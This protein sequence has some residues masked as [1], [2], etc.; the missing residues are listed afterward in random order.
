MDGSNKVA[1]DSCA[2]KSPV[3]DMI[4]TVTSPAGDVSSADELSE[5]MSDRGNTTAEVSEISSPLET[6][7]D[8][9]PNG[10]II[11]N[12]CIMPML[13]THAENAWRAVALFLKFCRSG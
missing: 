3:V 10:S 7:L 8:E 5:S 12:G 11:A 6:N 9:V 13:L 2:R 4:V 1:A